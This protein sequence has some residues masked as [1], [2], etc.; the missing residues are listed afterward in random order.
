M[1]GRFSDYSD[2]SHW[3]TIHNPRAIVRWWVTLQLLAQ[4]SLDVLE[5][6]K[7]GKLRLSLGFLNPRWSFPVYFKLCRRARRDYDKS[8]QPL[9]AAP[10]HSKM[11]FK[12]FHQIW[13]KPRE[14]TALF[15]ATKPWVYQELFES[16][17][18]LDEGASIKS[19]DDQSFSHS[20]RCSLSSAIALVNKSPKHGKATR[21][22]ADNSLRPEQSETIQLAPIRLATLKGNV[23]PPL[24]LLSQRRSYRFSDKKKEKKNY[25]NIVHP[26]QTI[27][28]WLCLRM[29]AHLTQPFTTPSQYLT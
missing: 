20:R 1:K 5:L 9:E 18:R 29:F 12:W 4:H 2:D 8:N 13:Y 27:S 15:R 23:C 14:K 6:C 25:V 21:F 26:N 10:S 24:I 11:T 17:S 16:F 3:N 28:I 7:R 22:L 19:G